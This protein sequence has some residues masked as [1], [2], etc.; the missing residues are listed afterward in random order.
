MP[1]YGN[2][3]YHYAVTTSLLEQGSGSITRWGAFIIFHSR[4][5]PS[6]QHVG[7]NDNF[8][9]HSQMI[10]IFRISFR[11][12]CHIPKGC[13]TTVPQTRWLETETHSVAVLEA[14]SL[15][16]RRRLGWLLLEAV[17]GNPFQASGFW[18]P[19]AVPGL[20][21]CNLCLCHYVA[22]SVCL[23]VPSS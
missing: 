4:C 7:K 10:I 14:W 6:T 21:Y 8:E 16:S 19:L 18:W 11:S 22:F 17:M 9:S 1:L 13:R 15:R 5:L 23:C 3:V 12:P 20:P 2:N